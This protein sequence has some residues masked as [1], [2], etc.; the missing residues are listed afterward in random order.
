MGSAAT[1]NLLGNFFGTSNFVNTSGWWSF[2]GDMS[3]FAY[4]NT[5]AIVLSPTTSND[6]W[7]K[8]GGFSHAEAYTSPKIQIYLTES[9]S[10]QRTDVCI[11][12]AGGL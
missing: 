5:Y 8:M 6:F 7:K 9:E 2:K 11:F 1:R 10:G 12:I 4:W 3:G